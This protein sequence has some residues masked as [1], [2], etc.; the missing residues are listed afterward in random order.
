MKTYHFIDMQDGSEL[1]LE[2]EFSYLFNNQKNGILVHDGKVL[3][4]NV[5][6]E[7]SLEFESKTTAT[8]RLGP[9]N[10]ISSAAGVHPNQVPDAREHYSKVHP[11]IQFHNNGD[12]Q[13][14]SRGARKAF[15]KAA[16]MHDNNGGYGD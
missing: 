9:K 7:I 16:G 1:E 8:V 2:L 15:L 12:V 13:F 10:R 11:G 5:A 14:S 4:R 6:K 3:K